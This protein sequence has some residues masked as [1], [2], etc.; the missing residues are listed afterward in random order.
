MYSDNKYYLWTPLV[1]FDMDKQDRGVEEYF[2]KIQ[3]KPKGISLFVFNADIV[4]MHKGMDK[5]IPF[6]SDYCNYFGAPR[7]ELRSIQPWTNFKFKE[8]VTNIKK[9][10][11]DTYLGIMGMHTVPR[12]RIYFK[13]NFGYLANQDF[14]L[15]NEE[16]CIEG[17][18]WTGH[19]Y[20]LKRLKDG[21]YFEDFIVN[22]TLKA[23]DDYGADGIH[24]ADAIFPPCMQ[25]QNGDYS[26]DMIE[27]FVCHSGIKLPDGMTKYIEGNKYTDIKE[28]ADYI[29]NNLRAEWI[30]FIAWR[31]NGFLTKLCNGLHAH[32]KKVM[33]NNCWM[34]DPF[35]SLYRY[36]IDYKSLS[37]AG[38]DVVCQEQQAS[39]ALMG[40]KVD[41]AN[42]VDEYY[43]KSMLMKAYSG[44]PE[45]ITITFAKDS[46]EEASMITH[47]P[48][49]CESE[50]YQL[51]NYYIYDNGCYKRAI[52]GYFIDLADA[53]SDNEWAWLIKRYERIF[54][55][56]TFNVIAPTLLWHDDY[57]GDN[58]LKDYIKTRR[59]SAHRYVA[60]LNKQNAGIRAVCKFEDLDSIN[61]DLFV[62]NI[63]VLPPTDIKK[64]MSYDKGIVVV[65]LSK[66]N[67]KYNFKG[68]RF[69]DNGV[70]DGD[71]RTVCYVLGAKED[72]SEEIALMSS[73]VDHSSE[74]DLNGEIVD[75]TVWTQDIIFNKV[76]KGFLTSMAKILKKA[77]IARH[78]IVMDGDK[79]YT[80]VQMPSGAKRLI[81]PN[82]NLN[83]Y[84]R[85][86][87]FVS[88]KFIKA[89][90][91][92]DFPAQPLKIVIEDGQAVADLGKK[93]ILDR[94]IGFSVKV[95]PGGIAVADIFTE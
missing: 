19:T 87:T 56:D 33:V 15:D 13:G 26:F 77:S 1:G 11:V 47:L 42:T 73:I 18:P 74:L 38:V 20:V 5:E 23:L 71:T 81:Y 31:W 7:N 25:L 80:I 63:D 75:T 67:D 36:G 30:R 49:I 78:G 45:C 50:Q 39:V 27:Q 79:D 57:M 58:F 60:Y 64:I 32:G 90:N 83:K 17:V 2:S 6:P 12:D 62:P 86:S 89:V 92:T 9:R 88:G 29:W 46:T 41:L 22:A 94:A 37:N 52:D 95:A 68:I 66:A 72:Y 10:G 34:S 93:E 35:E 21:T 44:K 53:L 61:A 85:T 48:S 8:L 91:K 40:R 76:S 28:R 82:K 16:G 51:A 43:C 65:T 4:Y 59:Y 54:A 69:E 84:D 14:F 24:L 3:S 70:S 55:D